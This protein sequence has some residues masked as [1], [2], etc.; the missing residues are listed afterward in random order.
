MK[1]LDSILPVS[2]EGLYPI[3]T[4]SEVSGVNSITLRA[5]E[6]RYDLFQPKRSAKGHRL[7]SEKDIKRIQQVLALLEKGVSIGRVAK[8]L[9]ENHTETDLPD[10]LATESK[11]KEITELTDEQCDAYKSKLLKKITKYNVMKL[12]SFH[13]ELLSNHSIES[14]SKKLF[15][16]VL[17]TLD[18]NAK[19]LPSLSS[20]YN[21]YRI[22]L[23][24]RLGGLCLKTTIH[25]TGKKL[26]LMGL[27]DEHC[28]VEMLLFA[29]PLLQQGFQVVT[30]GCNVS[31]DSIPMSLL[32]SKAEALLIF[33]DICDKDETITKSLNAI[34]NNIDHPVFVADQSS[35]NKEKQLQ[36]AG[37]IILPS[38]V[39]SQTT[40]INKKIDKTA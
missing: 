19:Q 12:E 5:W 29:M 33:S 40:L 7:Y 20:E 17:T 23:L 21:F 39:A 38:D 36:N 24:H 35:P 2:D 27:D 8:V 16:P 25:N 1:N 32:S 26:L 14:L 11:N 4:V 3:R 37:V 15:I 13:H 9:K 34:V 31:L 30:L 10:L 18:E 28:D 6:R 22:F